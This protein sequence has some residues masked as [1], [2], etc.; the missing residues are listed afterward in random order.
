MNERL[1]L[2]AGGVAVAFASGGELRIAAAGD[3][4]LGHDRGDYLRC[5]VAVMVG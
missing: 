4:G 5:G 1:T 2:N 3:H